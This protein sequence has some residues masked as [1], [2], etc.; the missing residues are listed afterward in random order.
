MRIHRKVY[1]LLIV[2]IFLVS[3]NLDTA[4]VYTWNRQTVAYAKSILSSSWKQK[5]I[6]VTIWNVSEPNSTVYPNIAKENYNLVLV[7]NPPEGLD[8][9]AKNGMKAMLGSK[10]LDPAS[11]H[12]P[13]KRKELDNLID[14]FKRYPALDAYF[15]TDEPGTAKFNGLAELVAYLHKRDPGKLAYINLFP[16]YASEEQLGVSVDRVSK[17]KNAYP[18]NL[19]GIGSDNKTVLVYLEH[20]RQFVTTVKP[21]IISYDHYHLFKDRETP[22]YFL[23]LALISQVSKERKLP[24]MNI[25]QAGKYE[26]NWRLPTAKEVRFQVYTTLAYGGRGISYFTYWGSDADESLYRNG[27][28]SPLAKDVAVINGE[29]RKLSPALMSLDSQSVYHTKTLPVGTEAIPKNSPVKVISDGEFVVGMFGKNK[30]ISAFMIVN[31]NYKERQIAEIKIDISGRKLQEL[32]R[33]TGKW[34]GV[35]NLTTNRRIKLTIEPGDGRLFR[36]I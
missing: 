8:V 6:I 10:L 31:R 23:N 4:K 11:L 29:I 7:N 25:I 34:I 2:L 32:N 16:T 21:D 12:D 28:Q 22:H 19:H 5:E 9:A 24:F 27:K 18:K 1:L 3:I 20:L 14:K 13:I 33:K 36:V 17:T 26:K 30:K 35:S 15:I